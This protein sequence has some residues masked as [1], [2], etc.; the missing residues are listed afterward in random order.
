MNEAEK[1]L[2]I[3]ELLK[4][5]SPN[6]IEIKK[7]K[8]TDLNTVPVKTEDDLIELTIEKNKKI[9]EQADAAFQM[10]FDPIARETDRSQAS[11][12][13]M[14]E[15]LKVKVELNKLLVEMAKIKKKSIDPKVGIQIN[16]VSPLQAGIDLAKI[17]EAM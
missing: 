6:E 13:M 3:E 9:E 11:K 4:E 14:V 12:E 17:K 10:F 16:T 2:S 7:E 1:D 15:A 5:V 8:I